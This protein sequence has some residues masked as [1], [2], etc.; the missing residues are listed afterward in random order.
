MGKRGFLFVYDSSIHSGKQARVAGRRG[1]AMS[2]D[3]EEQISRSSETQ[4]T[5]AWKNKTP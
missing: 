1:W 5:C 3:V 4:E 2:I